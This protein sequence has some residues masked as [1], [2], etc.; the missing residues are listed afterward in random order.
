MPHF[1]D[2]GFH[3]DL[4]LAR[5]N[6]Q[7][8]APNNQPVPQVVNCIDCACIVTTF[9]NVL[10]CDL[11]E[12]QM[13]GSAAFEVNPVILIGDNSWDGP[14][15]QYKFEFHE[16]AWK[17]ACT[18]GDPLFDACLQVDGDTNA[19]TPPHI[20]LLPANMV[21]GQQG[22]GLY[23]DRLVIRDTQQVKQTCAPRLRLP[24]RRFI[25]PPGIPVAKYLDLAFLRT[26]E[27]D[28]AAS[29]K[30]LSEERRARLRGEFDFTNRLAAREPLLNLFSSG[31]LLSDDIFP[32]WQIARS[33]AVR[34]SESIF[35][36]KSLWTRKRR[37]AGVLLEVDVY[38]CASRDEARE[39]LLELI[40]GVQL[41]GIEP[42]E[43][44]GPG[45]IAFSMSND[46]LVLFSRGNLTASVTTADGGA[47]SVLN[48]ANQLDRYMIRKP[49]RSD[50]E[51]NAPAIE[52]FAP[53]TE[54]LQVG[55]DV[56][57]TMTATDPSSQH[58][59]YRFFSRTGEVTS[60]GGRL[61]YRLA[62][63]GE[64]KITA[65]A[66]NTQRLQAKEQLKLSAG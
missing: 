41:P 58:L 16:V 55:L 51:E 22:D 1:T 62:T 14:C 2:R 3:C 7:A 32:G 35:S 46:I 52:H 64:H 37:N 31:F 4:F 33:A 24:A 25:H 27:I 47:E 61:R 30:F 29:S 43:A 49:R 44:G 28:F 13:G 59:W 9:A 6:K 53:E 39:F 17:G 18:A 15:G 5:L 50:T 34:I 21:F 36:I 45:D 42:L 12:A 26:L 38:E 60:D 63:G 40:E 11:S 10:G 20:P 48:K 56:P 19:A 57:L 23:R 65:F 8:M 66:L 54:D